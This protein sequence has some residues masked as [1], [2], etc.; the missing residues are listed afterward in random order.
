LLVV[1]ALSVAAFA[2]SAAA[3]ALLPQADD[4][5]FTA[6]EGAL[7]DRMAVQPITTRARNVI[8]F[9]GDGMSVATTTAARILD[10]QQRNV[11]GESNIL[12]VDRFPY[13]ALSKTYS[14][15]GQVSDSAPT[16]TAMVT[17]VKLRNGVI[18][19]D[20]SVA[21]GDCTGS[22]GH[23]VTT[24]FEQ[25]EAA[26]LATGVISTARI[27]H[28]TPAAMYSHTPN[29]DWEDDASTDAD[30]LA[31]GCGDIANQ[32]VNWSAGDGF[33]V[34]LGGG[35]SYFLPK[36]ASDPEDEGQT[37]RRLGSN[38]VE[39][40]QGMSNDHVFVWNEEGLDAVD[41]A[42]G[43]K[44]LGLFERSHM[45]YEADRLNDSGGEPSIAEMTATAIER[46]K[47]NGNGFVLMIEGGRIDHA[48]HAGNAYRALEDTIAF[49]EAIQTAIDMTNRSDTLIVVTADHSHTMT[50]NGYPERGNP[51]LGLV[52]E[53]G[54]LSLG[55]DGKPYT[56][57]SYANGPGGV[58]PA[59]A[60]GASAAEP[61]GVRPDLTDVDTTSADFIQQ[62]AVPLGSETHAG[63]DVAIYSWGPD[64]HLLQGTVEQ[65]MIYHVFAH[66]LGWDVRATN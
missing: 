42:S 59:L 56:T 2:S 3:Q 47:Q 35:R 1:T 22:K 5:Y 31:A 63:D 33:E 41:I 52:R 18:G 44:I 21:Y 20:S 25:A 60:T 65:N 27:T 37:G 4:P 49:N 39:E 48:H 10:G 19:M 45:E 12:P 50:I 57:I 29:R 30:A 8:L 46:L 62:A 9:V 24:L 64:A 61:A 11:D 16:A 28:A 14:D 26:G 36:T 51:I 34:I 54:E 6:A 7:M 17:G 53:G 43:A 23:E 40:W 32:L 13:L 38:L 58:F 66:A 15:D 55:A